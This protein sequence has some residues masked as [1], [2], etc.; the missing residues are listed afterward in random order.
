MMTPEMRQDQA[1]QNALTGSAKKAPS[2]PAK[3]GLDSWGFLDTISIKTP[4]TQR[5]EGFTKNT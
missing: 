1:F 2:G 5:I 3:G 4:A